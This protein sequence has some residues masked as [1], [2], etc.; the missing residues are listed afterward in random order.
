VLLSV[1]R[2]ILDEL[3]PD[4]CASVRAHDSGGSWD[5]LGKGF[6]VAGTEYDGHVDGDAGS[7]VALANVRYAIL[8]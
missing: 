4:T 7:G 6:L 8:A 3:D 2:N 1:V 5:V